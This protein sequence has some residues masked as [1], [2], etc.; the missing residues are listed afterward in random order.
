MVSPYTH[1]SIDGNQIDRRMAMAL[2]Y[3]KLEK[4]SVTEEDIAQFKNM[5]T[6]Q[7]STQHLIDYLTKPATR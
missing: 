4:L 5:L 3:A 7:L 6:G 2:S 1:D